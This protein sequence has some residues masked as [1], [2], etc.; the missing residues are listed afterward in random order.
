[1][2]VRVYMCVCVCVWLGDEA[3]VS[4]SGRVCGREGVCMWVGVGV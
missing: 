2:C 4:E 3:F 1:V